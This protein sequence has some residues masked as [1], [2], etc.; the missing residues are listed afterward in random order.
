MAARPI[1]WYNNVFFNSI[2]I[3]VVEDRPKAVE[4]EAQ[5]EDSERAE[6]KNGRGRQ[7]VGQAAQS[8]L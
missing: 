3:F 5:R 6:Q 2:T 4:M 7:K 8:E 1:K